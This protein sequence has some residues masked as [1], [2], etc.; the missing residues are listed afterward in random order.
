M[1]G[2]S[3]G[4]I[5]LEH[6]RCKWGITMHLAGFRS[7]ILFVRAVEESLKVLE[8]ACA[9]G[10]VIRATHAFKRSVNLEGKKGGRE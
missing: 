4:N 1:R 10:T 3:E 5:E 6:L 8:D 9:R 7:D 2:V